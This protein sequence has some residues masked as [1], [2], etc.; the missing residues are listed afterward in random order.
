[1]N[2]HR[3]QHS[4]VTRRESDLIIA[5]TY[6]HASKMNKSRRAVRNKSRFLRFSA[7]YQHVT[8][9]LNTERICKLCDRIV[10]YRIE[11]YVAKSRIGL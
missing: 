4:S 11:V 10:A 3:E 7:H 8:D 9:D 5:R 6:T 1:V 2:T